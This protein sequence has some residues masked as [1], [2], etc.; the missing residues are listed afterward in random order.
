MKK[1]Q[2]G[3][4]MAASKSECSGYLAEVSAWV[5]VTSVSE[6]LPIAVIGP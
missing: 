1:N 5:L 3:K 4:P 6:N 2:F